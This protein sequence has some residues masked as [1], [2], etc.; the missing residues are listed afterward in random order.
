MV[1]ATGSNGTEIDGFV[2]VA[3]AVPPVR[4]TDF[5]F[6]REQ[7]LTLWRQANDDGCAV[8]FFPELGL[9][10][11]TAGDLHLDRQLQGGVLESLTALLHEG[12]RRGLRPLAFVGMPLYVHPGLYNAAVALQG[13]RVLG[14]VPKG[15]L[16]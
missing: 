5:T 8:V 11:Y 3:V 7:T 9:S 13:G 14:V 1:G 16:P 10:S 2:R 6:N 12:D 4:V 15:Y